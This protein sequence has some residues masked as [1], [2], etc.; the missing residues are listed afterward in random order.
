[1]I[2]EFGTSAPL[3]AY[4]SI[5]FYNDRKLTFRRLCFETLAQLS[6]LKAL[7]P[8]FEQHRNWCF[9]IRLSGS[10]AGLRQ[11][12][13]HRT[14][15]Q[16]TRNANI[17][18]SWHGPTCCA[19][20]SLI[21]CTSSDPS[22]VR[23]QTHWQAPNNG[24]SFLNMKPPAKRKAPL[25]VPTTP[26]ILFSNWKGHHKAET[27]DPNGP[28]FILLGVCTATCTA[29]GLWHCLS[30]PQEGSRTLEELSTPEAKT[31]S[32]TACSSSWCYRCWKQL[33]QQWLGDETAWDETAWDETIATRLDPIIAEKKGRYLS[34]L[35]QLVICC[36][37]PWIVRGLRR[38]RSF[39]PLLLVFY[40]IN[41]FLHWYGK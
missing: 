15:A 18:C 24:T 34:C 5:L 28:G 36:F 40:F 16:V 22:L 35:N 12:G 11:P 2:E 4:I 27:M 38:F 7:T 13:G 23:H 32:A 21:P 31:T 1:M 14:N 29:P 20:I 9:I 17:T 10:R 8:F 30:T 6:K 25:S 41:G 37:I 3:W 39:M 26:S 19:L 33:K